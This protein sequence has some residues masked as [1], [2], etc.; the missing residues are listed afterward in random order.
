MS[1]IDALIL[2]SEW[3]PRVIVPMNIPVIT[4]PPNPSLSTAVASTL[5]PEAALIAVAHSKV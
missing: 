5:P 3:I 1:G 2:E 4:A